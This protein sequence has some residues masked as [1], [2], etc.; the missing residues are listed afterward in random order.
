MECRPVGGGTE[1]TF[2]FEAQA[3]GAMRFLLGP[4]MS[5]Y[6]KSWDTGLANLKRMMEAGEL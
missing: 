2:T 3:G 1:L 6:W 5:W 4:F